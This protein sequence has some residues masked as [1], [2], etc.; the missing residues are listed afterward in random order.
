MFPLKWLKQYQRGSIEF[1]KEVRGMQLN[2]TSMSEL[3]LV[4][5]LDEMYVCI[6]RHRYHYSVNSRVQHCMTVCNTDDIWQTI[7]F[8]CH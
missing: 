4:L 2:G 3:H 6:V 8:F 1:L 7:S 5:L